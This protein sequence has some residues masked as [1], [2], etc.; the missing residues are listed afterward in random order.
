MKY[1]GILLI[2]V[3][4]YSMVGFHHMDFVHLFKF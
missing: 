4:I 1:K 3:P 2:T